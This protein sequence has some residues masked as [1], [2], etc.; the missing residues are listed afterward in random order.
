MK[1]PRADEPKKCGQFRHPRLSVGMIGCMWQQ[2]RHAGSA[3]GACRR[4]RNTRL[5]AWAAVK[6]MAA[7]S[8]G[9]NTFAWQPCNGEWDTRCGYA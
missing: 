2:R 7:R 5:V 4:H 1:L 6:H 9:G 3:A 8:A